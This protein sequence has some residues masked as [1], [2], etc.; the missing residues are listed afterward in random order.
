MRVSGILLHPTSL[1]GAHGI[2]DLGEWAFRFADFLSD[3][4]QGLWQVLPLGPPAEANSPY[5]ACSSMAGNPLLISLDSLAREGLLSRADLEGAPLFPAESVDFVAVA[6]FKWRLLEQ[7]S[8]AFFAGGPGPHL[9]EFEQF[10]MEKGFWLDQFARF[11]ALRDENGGSLWT[12][13]DRNRNPDPARVLLHKYIQF[14]FFRQWHALKGYCHERGIRILGDLPIFVAHDSADVWGNP[15]LF[16]LDEHGNPRMIAGVPPDYFSATGQLWGNPLYRWDAMERA[17]YQ[18]WIDR[19]RCMLEQVD[20][21]RIDHF[22]GFEK[23]YEIP[24]GSMTAIH[25][26]WVEGPGDRF[27]EALSRVF[28]RLP[29]IA[30]DLGMITSEVLALRDRWGF[31]GMRVLQFA[32][33]DD[34]PS[35][36]FK[37]YNYVRNCIVYTGTHDND[38]TVGWFRG[39]SEGE[40]IQTEE[41]LRAERESALLYLHS[42]GVEIHWD[43]IRAAVGSVADTAVFPLQDVLGLGS[44]ARMNLPSRAENNWR[45]RFLPH[46]LKPEL[47]SRL[48]QLGQTYGRLTQ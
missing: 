33:A 21:I 18:W 44:E 17:G 7:A 13:W 43:F 25:G 5:K 45:W 38:T 35:N 6:A 1:P 37:P 12:E 40:I 20:L 31:P 28:G 11:A 2:G 27:F 9:R 14:E 16:D 3:G 30:E 8:R 48:R 22:R 4:G 41:Q 46:Q 34:S 29:F 42:D 24:A 19:V 36:P 10:C 32:F 15:G 23:Y 47:S 39:T 26:R